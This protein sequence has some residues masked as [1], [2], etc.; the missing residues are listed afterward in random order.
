MVTVNQGGLYVFCVN[1]NASHHLGTDFFI[2]MGNGSAVMTV[3]FVSDRVSYMTLRGGWCD[4]IILNA[5][6]PA[7][8]KVDDMKD[9]FY[10]ELGRV[11]DE[12]QKHHMKI[13]LGDFN[14]EAGIDYI[15]KLTLEMTVYME[16]VVIM[17]LK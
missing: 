14:A 10:E 15:F 17:R 13:L 2:Y 4:I 11:F 6:A 16:L 9:G 3:K 1:I 8:C 5:L 12:F 7:E